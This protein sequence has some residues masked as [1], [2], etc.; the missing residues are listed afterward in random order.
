MTI[1]THDAFKAFLKKEDVTYEFRYVYDSKIFQGVSIQLKN[2]GDLEKI[3]KWEGVKSIDP[4]HI[5]QIPKEPP[6]AAKPVPV[7]S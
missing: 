4:V 7:E 2:G 1:Q 6:Y 3:K 5:I